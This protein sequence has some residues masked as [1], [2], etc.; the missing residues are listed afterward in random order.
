MVSFEVDGGDAARRVYDRVQVVA[1]AA[2]LGEVSSLLTH[3]ASFSHKGLAPEERARLGLAD[4]LLRLSV[5][6]EDPA[7]LEHDLRQAIT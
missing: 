5:G 6:L 7:D 1:R 3:P 4:G 2:S